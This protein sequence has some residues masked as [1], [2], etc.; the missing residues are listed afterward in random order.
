MLIMEKEIWD[1]EDPRKGLC[2]NQGEQPYG[3]WLLELDCLVPLTL[4]LQKM[5]PI[6]SR[7]EHVANYAI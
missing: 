3:A 1:M 6:Y 2:C 4:P 7:A 5:P